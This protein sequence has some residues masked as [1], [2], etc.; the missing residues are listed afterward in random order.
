MNKNLAARIL[1]KRNAL[2]IVPYILDPLFPLQ[3]DF[4][5][6]P[7]KFKALFATRRFGKSY[8]AGLYLLKEALENPGVS[9]LYVA[10]T[11]DSAKGIMWKDILKV[12]N[13]RFKLNLKFNETLL[14]ATLP[15]GSVLYLMGADSS[16]DDKNKILGRKFKLAVIDEAASFTINMRELVYG[17]LKPAMADLNGTICMIGTPSNFTRGLFYD[18]TTGTE[19]GWHLVEANTRENPYMADKWANEIAE[20][21]TKQPYIIET[22]MFKQMYLGQWFVDENKLV[23][24]FN[25][26]RNLYSKLPSL[27]KDGWT[28]T[29]GIDLGYED[30]TAFVL[31]AYH[32]NDP[33]LYVVDTYNK[34]HMSLDQVASKILEYTSQKDSAPC[35]I[36]V[37]GSAKQAVESMRVRTAIPFEY[38]DKQG[39]ADFIEIL[40][41]DLVQGKVKIHSSNAKDLIDEMMALVWKTDGDKI[42]LPKREHPVLPNHL[43]DAFLYNW[44]MCYHFHATEAEVVVPV[45]SK[46]WYDKQSQDIWE[47]EREHLEK[48]DGSDWPDGGGFGRFG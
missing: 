46:A 48:Q 20:L 17:I 40:N 7:A 26:T 38:A 12:L 44:R 9:C 5:L 1:A 3:T 23:Y 39:K 15:N 41:S 28:Y 19:P 22:A 32:A 4:I 6:N 34:K 42:T 36:I 2:K 37:D 16:E 35:R 25:E 11:R 29:L 18:I 14:T 13:R 30:D 21:T 8:T 27:H 47:R 10:L 24:K 33:N 31:C 45:G 43:C